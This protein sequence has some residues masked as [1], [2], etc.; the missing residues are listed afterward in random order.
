[1]TQIA[2][3][4]PEPPL[5]LVWPEAPEKGDAADFVEQGG[6]QE[7]VEI[8]MS[9]ATNPPVLLSSDVVVPFSLPVGVREEG[10]TLEELEISVGILDAAGILNYQ[11]PPVQW[12]WGGRIAVGSFA[13]LASKPKVGKSQ[14]LLG[15]AL[16]TC[17]GD[18]P[19]QTYPVE[20]SDT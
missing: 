18:L 9:E 16:A 19:P 2:G 11:T 17:R 20:R 12:Q 6:T 7:R 10:I 3:L 13:L 1:M 15:L 14:L 4:L 5:M 8:L